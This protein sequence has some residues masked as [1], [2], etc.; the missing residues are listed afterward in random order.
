MAQD[1]LLAVP[2]PSVV[3][4]TGDPALTLLSEAGRLEVFPWLDLA[5]K[6]EHILQ[7]DLFTLAKRINLRYA[8]IY[9]GVEEAGQ[10]REEKWDELDAFTRYSNV[11]CADYHDIRP[12][13]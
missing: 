5:L 12:S 11:S 3:A 13:I 7:D 10:K 4:F 1:L 2:G 8:H 6:P 9:N